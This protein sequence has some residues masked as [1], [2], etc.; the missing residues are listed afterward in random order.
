M[1]FWSGSRC[2]DTRSAVA[3]ES[4]PSVPEIYLIGSIHNLHFEKR[5]RYSLVDL[6]R[7]VLEPH[8]DVICGEITPEAYGAL[9]EG[10]FPP[11]AAMLAS[12]MRSLI[13][14]YKT[15]GVRCQS[16]SRNSVCADG[17]T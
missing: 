13:A 8:L 4:V 15:K 11:E 3:S 16:S 17:T 10:N 1:R 12:Q 2:S 5:Y 6:Q 14:S 7:Q 9:M